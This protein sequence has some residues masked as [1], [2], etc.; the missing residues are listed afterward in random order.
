MHRH[1]ANGQ[2]SPQTC[3]TSWQNVQTTLAKHCTPHTAQYAPSRGKRANITANVHHIM[4]KY[5][6]HLGKTLHHT[7]LT[8]STI[9]LQMGK[10]YRKRAPHHG[11]ICKPPW[12]NIAPHTPHNMHRHVANGRLR[13]WGAGAIVG[14]LP[15]TS[16]PLFP[17]L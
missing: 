7:R 16:V 11:K 15:A 1:V 5:A 10:H 9:T 13:H 17:I 3:T 8:I 6:N 12:Q 14:A 2:T 4:A